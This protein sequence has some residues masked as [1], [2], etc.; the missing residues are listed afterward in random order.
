MASAPP[1]AIRPAEA[2]SEKSR[3]RRDGTWKEWTT[4]TETRSTV[5]G[6]TTD[7]MSSDGELTAW[8]N[9]AQAAMAPTAT[10]IFTH[11]GGRAR[12]A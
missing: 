5:S 1:T 11:A 12:V 4:R 10:T 6:L 9:H 8:K 7:V 2:P 3:S